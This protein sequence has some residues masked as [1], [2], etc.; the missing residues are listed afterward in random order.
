MLSFIELSFPFTRASVEK[1]G[2]DR[3]AANTGI[4]SSPSFFFIRF[5]FLF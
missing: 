3:A 5:R 4:F 2:T 1:E